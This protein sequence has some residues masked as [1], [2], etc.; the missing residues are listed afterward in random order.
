LYWSSKEPTFGFID[1]SL[2]FF[3]V[4]V[5]SLSCISFHLLVLVQFFSLFRSLIYLESVFFFF[6][7]GPGI[8]TQG[9][10]LAKQVLYSSSHTSSLF[11]SGYFED[12]VS[13][14]ICLCWPWNTILPISTSQVAR[15]TGVSHQHL[16]WIKYS[17]IL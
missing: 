13:Q 4:F 16:A 3:Y 8:W 14:T 10:I 11:C 2:M 12:E 17:K 1:F 15:I 6:L 7:V 5:Y 9:F